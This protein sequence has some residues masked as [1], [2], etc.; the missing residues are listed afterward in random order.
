MDIQAY[1]ATGQ[2]E[3]YALGL[4]PPGEAEQTA[5]YVAQYPELAEELNKI[6]DNL[7]RMAAAGA[8]RPP[9][10]LEDRI[11]QSI[12]AG[13]APAEQTAI[14][15]P[16]ASTTTINPAV[17]PLPA[18]PFAWA[19]AAVWILLTG[20]LLLNAFFWYEDQGRKKE[21]KDNY[22]E[23]AQLRSQQQELQ[24]RIDQFQQSSQT[25]FS[26]GSK[27]IPLQAVNGGQTYVLVY[28]SRQQLA[29]FDMSELPPPPDGK[30]YQMWVIVDGKPQSMGVIPMQAPENGMLKMQQPAQPGQQAFA[31]SL[32]QQGGS[33]TPT[34]VLML[35]KVQG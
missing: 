2:L 9:A 33:P 3:A 21:I 15:T 13:E 10:F 24:R 12:E 26:A 4:L 32:E 23:L 16:S 1:I 18:R 7:A 8:V 11:W 27:L 25:I 6:E 22:T 5:L 17:R 30:Q 20:S 31:I 19:Q 35:G 34:E 14:M 28:N 29:L